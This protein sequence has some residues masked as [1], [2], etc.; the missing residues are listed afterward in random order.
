MNE[1][2]NQAFSRLLLPI[3]DS[4]LL[5]NTL[6][7]LELVSELMGD[8]LKKVELVHVVGGSFLSTHL[9]NLDFRAGH[10]LS[11]E[12]IQRLRKQHHEE[13]VDPT[14]T[15]VQELLRR[16]GPGL[17]ANVRIEDGDPVKKI[18]SMCEKEGFSTIILARRKGDEESLFEGTVLYGI[19]HRFLGA[20]AYII[21]E[22]GFQQGRSPVA[23]I[24]IGVD[25]SVASLRAVKEAAVLMSRAGSAVEEV[26]LLHVLDPSCLLDQDG[27]D[28][29]KASGVGYKYLD[30]AEQILV[31]NGVEESKIVA[32]VLFGRPGEVL[33]EYAQS[34]GATM[35]YIGRRD[36]SKIA[37]V[38][39][40]S[41]CGDIIHRC[42][43]TT[44]ALVG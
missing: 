44:V 16:N 34:F 5:I 4:E 43:K 42:R 11:S 35:F 15:R 18:S 17:Q 3:K 41:V 33:T 32:T 20:S 22:D 28:C 26:A 12:V 8:E 37:K 31:N 39:L 13:F 1:V 19:L 24:M 14:L 21:G 25:G 23:R 2:K 40:G 7:L 10:V 9:K 29:Q 36:R 30:E 27:L 38:L 6:P